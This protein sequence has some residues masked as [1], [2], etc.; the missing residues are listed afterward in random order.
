[1]IRKSIALCL[2]LAIVG[3]AASLLAQEQA[4]DRMVSE[5]FVVKI[6]PSA[7]LKTLA[8]SPDSQRVAYAAKPGS[9]WSVVVDGKEGKAYARFLK[10][11]RIVFDSPDS[12]HYLAVK[13]G[14]NVYLVEEKFK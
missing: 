8:V 2:A 12:L 4:V 13:N 6:A 10:G 5:R 14:R 3:G 1:M 7:I 9:K 11:S